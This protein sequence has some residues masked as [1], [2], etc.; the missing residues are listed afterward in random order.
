MDMFGNHIRCVAAMKHADVRRAAEFALEHQ[1][2]PAAAFKSAI[3]KEAIAIALNL[4]PAHASMTGNARDV[5]VHPIAARSADRQLSGAP[6]SQLNTFA[7]L[8]TDALFQKTGA[9]QADFFLNEPTE[10]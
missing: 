7:G 4:V 2:M 3:A 9:V 5:D 8:P 6:P 1:A 10:G